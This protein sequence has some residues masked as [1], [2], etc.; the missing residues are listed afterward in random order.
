[1]PLYTKQFT[2]P[3][4][5]GYVDKPQKTTPVTADILNMQDD[6][7]AAVE[8]FLTSDDVG[9]KNKLTIGNRSSGN[10][11][12]KN[13]VSVGSTNSVTG[14]NSAAIGT[15]CKAYSFASFA[16]GQF[17][18]VNGNNSFAGGYGCSALAGNSFVDGNSSTTLGACSYAQGDH[19][20][21]S[22]YCQ[23]VQG[24]YNIED[25]QNKY[26]HIV[27]GGTSSTDKKNIHTLDWQG[28]AVFAGDVSTESGASLNS[29]G[30]PETVD[31]DFSNYFT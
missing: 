12:G 23:H 9:F 17:C 14:D 10:A 28:N 20:T 5:G 21:A 24:R 30:V 13:T 4:P 1:M 22:Q 18:S 8:D 19:V 15:N 26:A 3:Y 31:I 7:L 2:K 16:I 27:G 29:I 6:T 11:E 25:T